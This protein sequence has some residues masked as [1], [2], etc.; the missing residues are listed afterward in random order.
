M[1]DFLSVVIPV[2]FSVVLLR[3][4]WPAWSAPDRTARRLSVG[5][6]A[7]LLA[8]V[9]WLVGAGFVARVKAD[10]GELAEFRAAGVSVPQV[11]A[12]RAELARFRAAVTRYNEAVAAYNADPRLGVLKKTPVFGE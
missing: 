2:V 1:L 10:R 5:V 8:F 11:A 4:A 7:A 3:P 9:L 12:D 6:V